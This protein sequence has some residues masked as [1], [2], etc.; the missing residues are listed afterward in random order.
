MQKIIHADC[1][2]WMRTQDSDSIDCVVTDPPYGI[3]FMSEKWDFGIPGVEFWVEMLRICKP[4]SMLAAFGGT[5][6]YHRLTCA[7]EDAGW[8]IRD[9]VM[10]LYGSGFPKAMNFGKKLGGKWEGYSSCGLKPSHEPVIVAQKPLSINKEQDIIIANL[11]KLW[12]Q[13]CLMLHAN[14]AEMFFTSNNLDLKEVLSFA[15]M[16]AEQR[17]NTQADLCAL[18]DMSQ[19]EKVLISCLNIVSSWKTT[20][21]GLWK[22]GNMF[23]ILTKTNPIIDL[24]TLNYY[25]CQLTPLAIIQEETKQPGSWLNVLPV[26]RYLNAVEKNINAIQELFVLENATKKDGLNLCPN[27]EPIILAMKPLEKNYAFNAQKW[28][29]AG[30]NI[31][32]SRIEGNVP[33]TVQGQSSKQGEIYGSD[34]RSLKDFEPHNNGRWPSNLILDS[35]AA[36]QLDQQTGG[37]VSRFFYCPKASSSERNAGLEGML[38]KNDTPYDII[39]EIKSLLT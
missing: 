25:L 2:E 34:Q 36:A 5:R 20:L 38:L 19:L 15:Q 11:L 14:V 30:I 23:T 8:E 12:C 3:K 29:V 39:E 32:A 13:L 6:T 9:C 22:D 27:Y 17:S 35:E 10:W 37:N 7:I 18:M 1:L 33:K 4:G 24:K 21:E 28:G 31:D 16:N 26:A